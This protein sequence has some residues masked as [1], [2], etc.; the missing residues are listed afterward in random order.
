MKYKKWLQGPVYD[1]IV[2]FYSF[3]F[4][5]MLWTALT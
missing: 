1:D 2:V 5:Y 4:E 3:N